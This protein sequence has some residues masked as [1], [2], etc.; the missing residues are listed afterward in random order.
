MVTKVSLSSPEL[1]R[2]IKDVFV[3][4]TFVGESFTRKPAKF[5]RFIRPMGLRFTK[6]LVGLF[7]S[8]SYCFLNV[9]RHTLPIPSFKLLSASPL[10]VLRR[11]LQ[12]RCTRRQES[13]LRELSLKSTYQ[14]W[15]W[16]RKEERYNCFSLLF[17]GSMSSQHFFQFS[18]R[19]L[20]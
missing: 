4:V 2:F 18:I 16:S 7:D 6:V 14:N 8:F 19:Q 20:F 3:K 1:V 15:V 10:S 11:I 12:V 9:F 17:L 13:L 5:E